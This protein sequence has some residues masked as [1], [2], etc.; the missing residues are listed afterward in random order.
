MRHVI[1]PEI[2]QHADVFIDDIRF[3]GPTSTYNNTTL[4]DNPGIRLFVY[5][6]TTTVHRLFHRFIEA[7][8]T[9]SEMKLILATPKVQIIESVVSLDGWHLAYG[10]I[11]KVLKWPTPESVTEVYSFL[12]MAGVSHKWIKEFATIAKPLTNLC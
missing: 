2:P 11:S 1:K 4:L 6:Y 8:V 7:R 3:K 9:A 5:K 12:G 10:I